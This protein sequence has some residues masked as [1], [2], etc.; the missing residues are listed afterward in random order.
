MKR[1]LRN[2]WQDSQGQDLVE[3]ALA[4]GLVAV[5]AVAA[6]P[7]LTSVLCQVFTTVAGVVQNNMP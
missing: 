6:M 7:I 3:Y 1:S 4:V 2:L 5:G